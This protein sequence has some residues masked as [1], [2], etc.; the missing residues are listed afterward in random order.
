VGSPPK[1]LGRRGR[2]LLAPSTLVVVLASLITGCSSS[3]IP[4][5]ASSIRAISAAHSRASVA[6]F[7]AA[8]GSS[9]AL[10]ALAASA[11]LSGT[12]AGQYSG[13]Y[14]GTF[15]L[16]WQQTGSM[17]AGSITL[18]APRLTEKLNGTLNS[19]AITFGTVGPLT[20]TYAG[21][22]SAGISMSGAYQ[23]AGHSAGIWSASKS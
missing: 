10:S 16:T 22:E 20:I 3:A 1:P 7:T 23:V 8:A 11:D 12:W 2:A 21:T 6:E 17:L 18:S 19:T 14:Q 9:A 13:A 4:S 5:T 15:A